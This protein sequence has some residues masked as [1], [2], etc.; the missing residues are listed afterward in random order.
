MLKTDIDSVTSTASGFPKGYANDQN[1]DTWWKKSSGSGQNQDLDF[2]NNQ[3]TNVDAIILFIH[4]YLD[5]GSSALYAFHDDNAGFSS[6]TN[7]INGLQ[8][9]DTATPIRIYDITSSSERYWRVRFPNADVQVSMVLFCQKFT[10]SQGREFPIADNDDFA[11]R[12]LAAPG[13]RQY[14][15]IDNQNV[16]GSRTDK[17][18]LSGTTSYNA[19]RNAFL[20]CKKN[21]LPVLR[22]PGSTNADAELGRFSRAKFVRT[23]SDYQYYRPTVTIDLMPYIDSGEVY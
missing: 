7:V 15:V 8:L 5:V 6:A 21:G 18:A 1:P 19:L 9:Q 10:V 2:D 23:E 13:G 4:N 20:D 12:M 11:T 3:L 16:S 22:Q 14:V 17:F